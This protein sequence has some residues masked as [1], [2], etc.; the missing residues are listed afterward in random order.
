MPA[1]Y[2]R[3]RKRKHLDKNNSV[4]LY[5]NTCALRMRKRKHLSE[6]ENYHTSN[7]KG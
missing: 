2:V 5:V 6:R 7:Q 3:M 4:R 1:L